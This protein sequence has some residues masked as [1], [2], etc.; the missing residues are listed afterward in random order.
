M[1]S[2]KSLFLS[3]SGHVV[4][5]VSFHRQQ[6]RIDD[7]FNA[8][9][10]LIAAM[11]KSRANPSQARPGSQ[12]RWNG[13]VWE[14]ISH[15]HITD[16]LGAYSTHPEAMKANSALLRDFVVSMAKEAELTDWTVAILGGGVSE[17][18][19]MVDGVPVQR[20]ERAVK[21]YTGDRYSIGRLLS[22]KDEGI[23]IDLD[24]WQAALEE[25]RKIWKEDP[26]RLKNQK[27][28]EVPSGPA[29][30]RVRGHGAPGIMAH[31][32]RGALLIYLLDPKKTDGGGPLPES[33]PLVAFGISFPGSRS[34]TKV[35]YKVNNVLWEQEY[36]AAE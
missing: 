3:F 8:L 36:G 26:A 21:S 5:T 7:N 28:P 33:T 25:T 10:D 4:E 24:A 17:N 35:E 14:G 16:F 23:D 11:G 32:E 12:E 30:R 9:A 22:P 1:R 13:V 27:E 6:K 18:P 31:P 20:A 2:A 15:E 29:L 34:G 19:F